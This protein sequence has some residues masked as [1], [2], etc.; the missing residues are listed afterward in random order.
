VARVHATHVQ[1][2]NFAYSLLARRWQAT[3][4]AE[5][6]R[7]APSLSLSTLRHAFN[8][9]EPVTE[10]ALTDFL[11]AFVP[12]GLSPAALSPGYGLAENTVY[13]CDG[14]SMV[15]YVDREGLEAADRASVLA[16]CP[17]LSL[18]TGGGRAAAGEAR[19]KLGEAGRMASYVSC[20]PVCSPPGWAPSKDSSSS[21]GSSSSP[22]KN[23]DTWVLVV[24]P[25]T[26]VACEAEG[27]VGEIW[28]CSPSKAEG[29]DGRPEASAAAFQAH[30]VGADSGS[31]SGSGSAW[32]RTGDKGF[33]WRGELF[34][35]GRIKDLIISRG[36]NL[37][38]QDIEAA[39]ESGV[40]LE[41]PAGG[42]SSGGLPAAAAQLLL[43]PG[44]TAVFTVPAA[45]LWGSE[46]GG[47][48]QGGADTIGGGTGGVGT[49]SSSA[50]EDAL[51]IVAEVREGVSAAAQS[52]AVQ[53][54]RTI[55][56]RDFGVRP[57]GVLLLRARGTRKTTSGKVSRSQNAAAFV[58]RLRGGKVQDK[59]PWGVGS[60]DVLLEWK[61]EAGASGGGTAGGGSG[62]SSSSL[63]LPHAP[64]LELRALGV[65]AG[66]P[67]PQ[68][69]LQLPSHPPVGAYRSLAGPE[70]VSQLKRDIAEMLNE[71]SWESVPTAVC[72]LEL[73]MDSLSLAQLPPRLNFEYGFHV[74]DSQV[75]SAACTIDWLA[76]SAAALRQGHVELPA[77][78]AAA[79]APAA[80][81]AGEATTAAAGV[82]MPPLRPR[83]AVHQATAFE[84]SCP[85]FLL[86]WK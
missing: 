24:D 2:P 65:A 11:A 58:Q 22:G 34:V 4:Q 62:P 76:S 81:G 79:A 15:V 70:L 16:S 55:C 53:S 61:G 41:D 10:A 64:T 18:H 33:L 31:G 32:L 86:C 28:V 40:G 26:C 30:T 57:V 63:V 69:Q 52:Q 6:A 20:G 73:G 7:L 56:A 66:Q 46:G 35:C 38:P 78:S 42:T 77:V 68:P 54:M 17:I 8:A 9:A 85:C 47:G 3:P 14:G 13:V 59:N 12:L 39:I 36:R 23:A 71:G 51:I 21:S 1:A 80:A 82:P 84:T 75:F 37:Y 83:P 43:R 50:E 49:G 29:Y 5:R 45:E 25:A 48:A 44:A 74:A 67:Q 72:L 19:A 27:A 60:T